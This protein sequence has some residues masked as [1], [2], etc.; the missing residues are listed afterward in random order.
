MSY[1]RI[2]NKLL[3]DRSINN[4]RLNL[5]RLNDL[6]NKLS[7]GKNINAPSDDPVNLNRLLNI[8]DTMKQ[9]ERYLDNISNAK[10]ELSTSD[11]MLGSVTDIIQRVR[12]LSI[13]ASNQTNGPDELTAIREEVQ[14]LLNQTVQIANTKFGDKYIFGGLVTNQPPF[15]QAGATI[16]YN[17][18]MSP[19]HARN[20]EVGSG[21]TV[22]VNFS[23]DDI[24]GQ[25]N[26]G[27]QHGLVNTL[28]NLINDLN[29]TIANPVAANYDAIRNRVN[30]IDTDMNTILSV[31]TTVGALMNRLDLTENRLQDR[32]LSLS[33]EYGS[34]QDV[35]LAKVVADLNFQ[36]AVF[37]T[38]LST[39]ARVLQPSLMQYL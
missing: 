15:T 27:S 21:V 4:L 6:Q 36:E 38:S 39:T 29:T 26:G 33:K 25:N 12:E 31:Q 18:S 30:N 34:I 5:N 37:Q 22:T 24:F 35:D 19:N 11:S 8:E 9:D 10:S 16:T 13:Q 2:T 3:S 14:Q 28:A 20:V 23:G 7:S 32:Q 1:A 17:G